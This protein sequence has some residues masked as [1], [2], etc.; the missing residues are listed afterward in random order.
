MHYKNLRAEMARSGVT[1]TQLAGLLGVR[2]A[3]V[4]DKMNGR[5]RFFCDEAIRIKREFFP[6]LTIEYL[7]AQD[8]QQNTA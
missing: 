1:I 4:S 2:F 7:F 6:S 5:S 8:D 3:T